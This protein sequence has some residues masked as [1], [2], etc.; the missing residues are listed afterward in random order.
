MSLSG[1][2]APNIPGPN[3]Y[4]IRRKRHLLFILWLKIFS[5]L[6]FET[7]SS[8]KY[9]NLDIAGFV[10]NYKHILLARPHEIIDLEWPWSWKHNSSCF[11][12]PFCA[13]SENFPLIQ[14]TSAFVCW[15]VGS[16]CF[17]MLNTLCCVVNFSSLLWGAIFNLFI[18]D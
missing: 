16:E 10:L 18:H 13:R 9:S 2:S 3:L 11:S 5:S 15:A 14:L 17:K 1:S 12:L 8:T 6:V 7:F 4:T